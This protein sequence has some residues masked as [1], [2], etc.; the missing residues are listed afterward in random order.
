MAPTAT[1][2]ARAR[3]AA[4]PAVPVDIDR[5]TSHELFGEPG[6][7]PHGSP[8]APA[9]GPAPDAARARGALVAAGLLDAAVAFDDPQ[10][11][12]RAPEPGPR[13]GLAALTGTL[14]ATLLTWLVAGRLAVTAVGL[15]DP[16]SPGRVVGPPAAEHDPG[17]RVVNDRYRAEHP[18]LLAASLTHDL[19]WSGEAAGQYEECILHALGA[20][21]HVQLLARAPSLASL[22]TELA[23]RQNSLA[24]TLLNSRHPGRADISLIAADGAG[25]IPG[26]APTMQTPDFWSIPFVPGAPAVTD[27]P[28]ALAPVLQ[29]LLAPGTP[30]PEPLRWAPELGELLSDHL[31]RAWLPLTDQLVAARALGLLP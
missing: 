14:A 3:L 13:A 15:G 28:D 10:L 16:Q 11:A 5:F 1:D 23:R 27:A 22:G 4:P 17:R 24:I 20:M 26:G 12:A 7:Y 2:D 18:A 9:G 29:S 6:I 21:V 30:L 8:M 25:T 19:L 31:G